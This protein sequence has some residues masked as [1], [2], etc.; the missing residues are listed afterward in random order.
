MS[1]KIKVLYFARI[2]EAVNTEQ[3]TLELS[4][5]IETAGDVLNLLV[6]RGEP[7]AN[8]LSSSQLLIA[9]NQEM[10]NA[11]APITEGDEVAFFPPVTGG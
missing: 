4:T 7:W 2:R 11:D 8:A 9:V 6:D 1:K 3:E 5:N 10:T